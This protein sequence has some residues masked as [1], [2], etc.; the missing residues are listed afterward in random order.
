MTLN[1]LLKKKMTINGQ[2]PGNRKK[3]EALNK[4][5]RRKVRK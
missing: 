2:Q 5:L 4:F 3:E 1:D